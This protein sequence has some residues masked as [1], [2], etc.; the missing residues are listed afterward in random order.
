MF[1]TGVRQMLNGQQVKQA[2]GG[3]VDA[4]VSA[5]HIGERS[6]DIG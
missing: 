2:V 3:K 1:L 6:P 5:K 4:V